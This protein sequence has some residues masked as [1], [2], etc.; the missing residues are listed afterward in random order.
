MEVG[1]VRLVVIAATLA[2]LVTLPIG[3]IAPATNGDLG[4]KTV[5]ITPMQQRIVAVEPDSS[6]TAAGGRPGDVV[7]VDRMSAAQ[8][9]AFEWLTA[10]TTA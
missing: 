2:V 7:R 9:V 8:R 3:W 10:S 6:F 1:H 5:P 4:I